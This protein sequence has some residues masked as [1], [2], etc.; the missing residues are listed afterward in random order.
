MNQKNQ[1]NTRIDFSDSCRRCH[2][3]SG[4]TNAFH[5]SGEEPSGALQKPGSSAGRGCS[6]QSRCRRG[7]PT[8]PR[9][10]GVKLAGVTK[11]LVLSK[12]FGQV[13][14]SCK[15]TRKCDGVWGGVLCH[16]FSCVI[17]LGEAVMVHVNVY[18]L[19]Q[20]AEI[21]EK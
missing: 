4:D 5:V 17:N 8:A 15:R 2:F 6:G 7:S 11:Q 20:A 18:I 16:Y 3:V 10:L 14:P 13:L 1:S 12:P 9:A 21:G 19:K